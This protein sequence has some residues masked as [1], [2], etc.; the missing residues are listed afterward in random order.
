[1]TTVPCVNS[2]AFRVLTLDTDIPMLGGSAF[3]S[4]TALTPGTQR[5]RFQ[6]IPVAEWSKAR[7]CDPSLVGISGSNPAGDMGV[8]VVCSSE[9]SYMRTGN[10]I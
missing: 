3:G 6:P 4:G 10:C 8:C 5:V 9:I 7:D 1:M 2:A